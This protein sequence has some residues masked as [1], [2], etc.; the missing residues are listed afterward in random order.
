MGMMAGLQFDML[1][2]ADATFFHDLLSHLKRK[3]DDSL[4]LILERVLL[5]ICNH[6]RT[7][8]RARSHTEPR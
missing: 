6:D 5:G 4:S 3:V 8:R 1:D 2:L 7:E